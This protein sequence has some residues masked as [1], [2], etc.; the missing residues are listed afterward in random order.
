M[1]S[2]W[3][4]YLVSANFL[5]QIQRNKKVRLQATQSFYVS[6]DTKT[7]LYKLTDWTVKQTRPV[8]NHLKI[9][10]TVWNDE[11]VVEFRDSPHIYRLR[12]LSVS[13]FLWVY[14]KRH[15]NVEWKKVLWCDKRKDV[16]LNI[17]SSKEKIA[18]FSLQ[19]IQHPNDYVIKTMNNV[20]IRK[21]QVQ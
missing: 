12:P 10:V 7:L 14:L 18:C 1:Q 17:L 5:F 16:F 6:D 2:N 11:W 3:K 15:S 4:T 13:H 21:Y 19:Q 9:H 8:R 20:V